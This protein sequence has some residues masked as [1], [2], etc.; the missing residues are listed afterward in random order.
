MCSPKWFLKEFYLVPKHLNADTGSAMGQIFLIET[1]F[2]EKKLK[3]SDTCVESVKKT[4]KRKF[5][6]SLIIL[7]VSGRFFKYKHQI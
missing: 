1:N 3:K 2:E 5:W 4:V 6:G 7:S